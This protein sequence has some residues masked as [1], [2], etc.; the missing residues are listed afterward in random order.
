MTAERLYL[1]LRDDI[2]KSRSIPPCQTT[3]PELW[4]GESGED[5]LNYKPAKQFCSRCPVI[6]VCLAYALEANELDGVWGGLSPLERR[7]MRNA[8]QRVKTRRPNFK[9]MV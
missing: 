2:E 1:K 6:D 8:Q 3:D 9:E 7:D 4:Y 5:R